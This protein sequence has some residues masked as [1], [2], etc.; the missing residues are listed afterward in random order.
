MSV[1]AVPDQRR[2]T[3]ADSPATKQQLGTA[4]A[5]S[6]HPHH[7]AEG[8]E[9]CSWLAHQRERNRSGTLPEGLKAELDQLGM[10]W[11]RLD[12][13]T[14]DDA[15]ALAARFYAQHQHLRTPAGYTVNGFDLYFW[16]CQQ[17]RE[18]NNGKLADARAAALD[19][20]GMDWDLHATRWETSFAA[21]YFAREG[22]LDPPTAHREDGVNL[23]AWLRPQRRLC[24]EGRLTQARIE[25]LNAIGMTW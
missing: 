6:R 25:R 1:N 21:A 18:R 22:D 19:A 13:V 2:S 15:Y 5:S 12:R 23:R 3:R 7:P 4:D 17:R 16:L 8:I 9:L 14:W 10:R 24:R 20:I 11:D